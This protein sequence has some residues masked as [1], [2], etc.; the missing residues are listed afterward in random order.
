MSVICISLSLFTSLLYCI[1]GREESTVIKVSIP[2]ILT[3]DSLHAAVIHHQWPWLHLSTSLW[4][5]IA[6]SSPI[7][8]SPVW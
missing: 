7:P 4:D 1:R 6:L 3:T 2:S 5:P 8:S